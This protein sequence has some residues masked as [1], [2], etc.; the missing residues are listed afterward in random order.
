LVVVLV[1]VAPAGIAS[2]ATAGATRA[3]PSPATPALA[4]GTALDQDRSGELP[5]V[6]INEAPGD[7]LGEGHDQIASV[8]NGALQ[9]TEAA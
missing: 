1:A 7:Y 8:Q 9:I 3:A 4:S 5:V 2:P 6:N